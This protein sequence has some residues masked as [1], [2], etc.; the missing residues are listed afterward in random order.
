MS[1]FVTFIVLSDGGRVMCRSTC[2]IFP[3]TLNWL[4]K[5]SILVINITFNGCRSATLNSLACSRYGPVYIYLPQGMADDCA[6]HYRLAGCP[7]A[8]ACG[9]YPLL[10]I[11]AA[12]WLACS[13]MHRHWHVATDDPWCS[14]HKPLPSKRR[15]IPVQKAPL[16]DAIKGEWD[17]LQWCG[18]N[19]E[20]KSH[21]RDFWFIIH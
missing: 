11:A 12:Y 5:N 2:K 7:R 6:I 21:M 18:W 14:M 15:E 16:I 17:F 13:C 8:A 19:V 20:L 4:I 1:C 3:N 10:K 9:H